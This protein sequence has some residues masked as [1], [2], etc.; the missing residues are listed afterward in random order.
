[1]ITI[2]T[3]NNCK[4]CEEV[5]HYMDGAKIEYEVENIEDNPQALKLARQSYPLMG[6]PVVVFPDQT[7]LAGQTEPIIKKL[8]ELNGGVTLEPSTSS[9]S[10][11]SGLKEPPTQ[12][13]NYDWGA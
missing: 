11:V 13:A 3:R 9:L 5:K 10:S 7:A 4:R 8:I 6:F 12:V 2:Y 1:M